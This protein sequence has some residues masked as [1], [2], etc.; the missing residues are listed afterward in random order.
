MYNSLY[1]RGAIAIHG[2]NHVPPHPASAGCVR[3]SP[4]AA[5][6]L[7]AALSIGDPVQVIGSY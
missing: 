6:Q 3:V 2:S 4:A 5:D 7:F 1:F